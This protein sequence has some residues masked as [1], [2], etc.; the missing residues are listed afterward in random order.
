MKKI[1]IRQYD[2]AREL[3]WL[4]VHASVMVDSAA[5][6]T[7]LHKKPRY[8]QP[9]VDLIV[10]LDNRIVGFIVVE[11]N[12]SL[13]PEHNPAGFVWEFGVQRDH[14]GQDIGAELIHEAHKIMK[15]KHNIAKSIW[16]SQEPRAQ[17]YYRRLGMHEVG[18]HW[19]FS[20][21]PDE[22]MKKQFKRDGFDCWNLR[23][24]CAVE[25][26]DRVSSR[27]K[28]IQDDDTLKPRLCIGFEYIPADIRDSS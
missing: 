24:S 13:I 25:D 18:Q 7:V 8:D 2:P 14:R 12:S 9:V 6:W 15:R 28:I 5:W 21:E 26:F 22:E 23:G 11:I 4:D 1:I 16:Y 10:L 3:E 27:F 17:Q 19:Q 20:I